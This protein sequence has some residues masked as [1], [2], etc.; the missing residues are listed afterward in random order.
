MGNLFFPT[1]FCLF[2]STN[3]LV[4]SV[5]V[6]TCQMEFYEMRLY[7]TFH[8]SSVRKFTM[9]YSQVNLEKCFKMKI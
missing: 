3:P 5:N 4:N 1:I 7:L 8:A 2:V 6:H 9:N